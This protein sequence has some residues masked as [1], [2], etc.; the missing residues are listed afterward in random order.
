PTAD[1][2]H[3]QRFSGGRWVDF[4]RN[5]SS[6]DEPS[7]RGT[8]EQDP[9]G[10]QARRPPGRAAHE[11]RAGHQSPFREGARPPNSR[12]AAGRCRRGHRMTAKMKRRDFITLLS[13]AAVWPLAARAQQPERMRRIGVLMPLGANDLQGQARIAAFLQGLRQFGWTDQNVRI[14][15]RWSADNDGDTRKY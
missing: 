13:G 6:A 4:L 2:I 15:Y 14:D 9:Q 11:I 3:P 5:R 8:C 12:Q 7:C 1:D 10:C